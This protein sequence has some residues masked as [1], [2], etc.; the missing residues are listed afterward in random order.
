MK[1]PCYLSHLRKEKTCL[2]AASVVGAASLAGLTL[3]VH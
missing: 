3:G 2:V 1:N